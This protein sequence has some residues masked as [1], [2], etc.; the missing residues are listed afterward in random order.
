MHPNLKELPV[1]KRF[2][3]VQGIGCLLTSLAMAAT[4]PAPA[5]PK[6]T[7]PPPPTS[8]QVDLTYIRNQVLSG[9]LSLE[10]ELS[11]VKEQKDNM[12]VKRGQLLP[13]LNIGTNIASGPSFILSQIQFLLPFLIPSNWFALDAATDDFNA[14]EIAYKVLELNVYGSALS[15]YFTIESD[16]QTQAVYVQEAKDLMDIYT[17]KKTQNDLLGTVPPEQLSQALASAQLAQV[18]PHNSWSW[19]SKNQICFAR[20]W[21]YH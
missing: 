20:C 21:D 15:M 19:R 16:Y 6:P 1:I 4:T 3:I 5:A 17:I 7:T 18:Q 14:E 8:V 13:S 12:D 10:Q 11:V 2:L 9:N